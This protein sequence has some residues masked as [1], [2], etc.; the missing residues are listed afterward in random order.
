MADIPILMMRPERSGTGEGGQTAGCINAGM[1]SPLSSGISSM[2]WS[3]GEQASGGF[4]AGMPSLLSSSKFGVGS[5]GGFSMGA[6]TC[7]TPSSSVSCPR[8]LMQQEHAQQ[9]MV[10]WQ[11]MPAAATLPTSAPATGAGAAGWKE[12]ENANGRKYYHHAA[13]GNTQWDAPPGWGQPR[14]ALMHTP[15]TQLNCTPMQTPQ[16]QKK[17]E[18]M[19]VD[20]LKDALSSRKLRKSGKKADLVQVMMISTACLMP[21]PAILLVL[22]VLT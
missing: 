1:P 9:Q 19:K 16:T 4:N 12:Y 15:Q 10:P 3:M 22:L 13:S 21:L 5:M 6:L 8:G 14:L 7:G 2:G 17:Y 11:L 20:E 18:G